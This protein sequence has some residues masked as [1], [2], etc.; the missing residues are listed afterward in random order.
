MSTLASKTYPVAGTE[1]WNGEP[2]PSLGAVV[3][4]SPPEMRAPQAVQ[5]LRYLLDPEGFFAAG[6][7]RHGDVF[8]VR[9]LGE[10]WVVLAHPDHVKELFAHGPDDLNSGEPNQVLRPVLGTRNLL[11]L[12]GEE[13]LHRR[14]MVLPPFHGERMRAYE[15]AIRTAAVREIE[16]W[17]LGEPIAVLGRMQ[18]LTFSVILRCVF[19]VEDGERLTALRAQLIQLL[20]WVTDLRRV[21]VFFMLGPDRLM[22]LPR[23]RRQVQAVDREIYAEIARRRRA[24]D[25]EKRED[26]LSLLVGARDEQ[27]RRLSDEELRD[28]LVTLL[29]AGHETTATL[30]AWAVHELA[31]DGERQDRLAVEQ[32]AFSD[33]V[34][35]ETL[36]LHP[37]VA[38]VARRL[39]RPLSLAGYRLA[40]G[41]NMMP[42][43]L[44]V[45]RRGDVYEQ[46]WAFRPERFLDARPPAGAW[47]PFGG[48]VRRCIGASFA[49]FEARIVLEEMTR[50]LRLRAARSRPER[51]GRRAIVL[52]PSR[53][54]RVVARAR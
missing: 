9:V 34:I 3:S 32:R 36:R 21:I 24:Q 49:Q 1:T 41:T 45:H 6:Q 17:P 22:A 50:R 47:L 40:A 53:G 12:D 44:L 19:G 16:G 25:L 42:V 7:R 48:S 28:E 43:S 20:G 33:A 2:A 52:V 23:F 14:R 51:T 37:P 27:G 46:P 35:A 11:L 26:I 18:A 8:K 54:A 39:R 30:I 10:E 29:I 38:A 15:Q 4:R 13:H 31:R 5:T